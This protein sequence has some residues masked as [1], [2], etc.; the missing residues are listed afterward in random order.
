[1]HKKN[2]L[3]GLTVTGIAAAASLG[4]A[5][6]AFAATPVSVTVGSYT[7][8]SHPITATTTGT[9]PQV[10]FTAGVK[11]TCDQ[12]TV[13]GNVNAGLFSAPA[14]NPV[15]SVTS[16][17]T[18]WVNCLG[19]LGIGM[20]VIPGTGAW[21]LNA[22]DTNNPS[23][24]ITQGTVDNVSAHVQDTSSGGATCSFDV[25]GSVPGSFNNSTQHLVIPG[26]SSTLHV[27]NIVGCFG[28]VTS[29]ASFKG[30]FLVNSPDGAIAIN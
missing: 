1:M 19:P 6:S 20:T 16:T 25:S 18:D 28:L 26:T 15:A 23:A 5:T 13:R 12:A 11:M 2:L 30:D 24:G 27:S 8:G 10:T 29:T 21:D 4:L 9:T 14:P 17:S 7:S 3:R 22:V